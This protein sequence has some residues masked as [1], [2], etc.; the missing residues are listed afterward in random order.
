M[1][2]QTNICPVKNGLKIVYSVFVCVAARMCMCVWLCVCVKG[3]LGVGGGGGESSNVN[4]LRQAVWILTHPLYV[5]DSRHMKQNGL[6]MGL[7]V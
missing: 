4:I 1:F 2:R 3:G 6:L 5:S 7:C